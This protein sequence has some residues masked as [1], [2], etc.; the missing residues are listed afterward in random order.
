MG[1][2][3]GHVKVYPIVNRVIIRN[4]T[5]GENRMN[6]K[7]IQRERPGSVRRSGGIS[8]SEDGHEKMSHCRAVIVFRCAVV[9][10]TCRVSS[11][12]LCK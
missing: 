8:G 11:T 12:N 5:V 7:E 10:R 9:A 6:I 2:N 1:I 3:G 4:S